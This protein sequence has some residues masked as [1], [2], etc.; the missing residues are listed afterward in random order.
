[1]TFWSGPA[2]ATGA[3]FALAAV[4]MTVSAALLTVPS[5]TV[6]EIT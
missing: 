3:E 2:L 4:T 6:R 5:F 1:M